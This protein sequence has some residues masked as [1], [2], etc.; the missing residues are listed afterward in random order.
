MSTT[1]GRPEPVA[2]GMIATVRG[3]RKSRDSINSKDPSIAGTR[4]KPTEALTML[5]ATA[6]S[7]DPSNI[8]RGAGNFAESVFRRP[9]MCLLKLTY[10][11]KSRKHKLFFRSKNQV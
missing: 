1:A 9:Q 6:S 7:Q 10:L 8:S 4:G 11:R 5:T 3:A 2:A